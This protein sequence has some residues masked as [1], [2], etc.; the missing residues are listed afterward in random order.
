MSGKEHL[1]RL[2]SWSIKSRTHPRSYLGADGEEYD[3]EKYHSGLQPGESKKVD[4]I[5]DLDGVFLEG[6]PEKARPYQK[7]TYKK[8]KIPL[9]IRNSEEYKEIY[10]DGEPNWFKEKYG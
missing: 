8:P 6:L 5:N 7:I 3:Y 10:G 2:I 9:W 4:R 1:D